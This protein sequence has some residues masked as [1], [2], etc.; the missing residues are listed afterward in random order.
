MEWGVVGS[1]GV[2][3]GSLSPV[4]VLMD[5]GEWVYILA[6]CLLLH[7]RLTGAWYG[8]LFCCLRVRSKG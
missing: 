4:E 6:K 2:G 8:W 3:R 7:R 5:V 1:A